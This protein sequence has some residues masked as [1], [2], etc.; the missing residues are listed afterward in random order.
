MLPE[1]TVLT[2]IL[3]AF[4]GSV[5]LC[6]LHA[7]DMPM[8]NAVWLFAMSCGFPC[9]AAI[10]QMFALTGKSRRFPRYEGRF[11]LRLHEWTAYLL[12]LFLL[13]H[14]LLAVRAEP[15]LWR[16]M[17]PP[18]GR[19]M[20]TGLAAVILLP[21]LILSSRTRIRK[22]LFGSADS[23]RRW[24][25]AGAVLLLLFSV[26]HVILSDLSLVG[27]LWIVGLIALAMLTVLLPRRRGK[28]TT[29]EKIS[30]QKNT[31]DYAFPV[32]FW[33]GLAGL[34]VPLLAAVRA[35]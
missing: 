30:R 34:L 27:G 13:L 33:L 23:F 2:L 9:L 11:F 19:V 15:L 32:V 35:D 17:W 22:H 10:L 24:H 20:Q 21:L 5:T 25:Y 29:K 12:T 28:H 31:R 6:G 14:I 26:L 3:I 8:E 4:S 18:A 1:W 7:T 16:D